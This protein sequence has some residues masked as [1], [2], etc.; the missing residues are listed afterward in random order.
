MEPV[1]FC[2]EFNVLYFLQTFILF[3]NMYFF[4]KLL[5][6]FIQKKLNLFSEGRKEG[7]KK[8]KRITYSTDKFF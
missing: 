5:L 4:N 7:T 3:D 2:V 8:K 6:L 1:A